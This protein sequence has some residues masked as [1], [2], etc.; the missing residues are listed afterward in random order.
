MFFVIAIF[1]LSFFLAAF[2]VLFNRPIRKIWIR[3][4]TSMNKSFEEGDK[5]DGI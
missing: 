3:F 2:I 4:V 1:W 5:K